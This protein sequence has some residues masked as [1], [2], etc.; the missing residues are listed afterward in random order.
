MVNTRRDIVSEFKH[1]LEAK[2]AFAD[3]AKGK[4]SKKEFEAKGYKLAKLSC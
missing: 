3:M 1:A 4:I 2:R